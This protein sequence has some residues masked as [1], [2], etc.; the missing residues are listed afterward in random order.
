M[1]LKFKEV[2]TERESEEFPVFKRYEDEV[3][4]EKEYEKALKFANKNKKFR[5]VYTMVDGEHNN[6]FYLKGLHF[7]NRFAFC[8]LGVK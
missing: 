7:V 2:L 6:T 8:V 5:K 3:S 1:K 4:Y